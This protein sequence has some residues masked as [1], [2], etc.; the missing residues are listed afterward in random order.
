MKTETTLLYHLCNSTIRD[1]KLC[2]KRRITATEFRRNRL[3]ILIKLFFEHQTVYFSVRRRSTMSENEKMCSR[4]LCFR[5]RKGKIKNYNNIQHTTTA[6]CRQT[7]LFLSSNTLWNN[8]EQCSL[9]LTMWLWRN[10]LQSPLVYYQVFWNIY[11]TLQKYLFCS[12][13]GR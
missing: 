1:K 9:F 7:L 4:A 13:P 12:R 2:P 10:Q 11:E 5:R 3:G 6:S 8:M